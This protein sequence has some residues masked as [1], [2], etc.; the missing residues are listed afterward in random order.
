MHPPGYELLAELGRGTTGVVY[1]AQC[2]TLGRPAAIQFVY[3]C[4]GD[5]R[6]ERDSRFV[7]AVRIFG[8]L[9]HPGV[10]PAHAAGE[11]EGLPYCVRRYID[12]DT[13]EALA[14]AKAIDLPTGLQFLQQ[15]AEAVSF[16]HKH[17]FVHRTLYPSNVLV[18]AKYGAVQLIGFGR[19][20]PRTESD[21][22][23]DAQALHRMLLWLVGTLG[24]P[25][26]VELSHLDGAATPAA[27][28]GA[29]RRHI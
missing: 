13:L 12:G 23:R 4:S 22:R 5:E 10:L 18:E 19:A 17:G 27:L 3:P 21:A 2:V 25:L 9:P 15:L 28:A 14:A 8:S 29:L 6:R 26:P 1:K 24:R 16:I 7:R 11:H 20:K